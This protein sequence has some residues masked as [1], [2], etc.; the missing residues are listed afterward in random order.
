MIFLDLTKEYDALDRYRCLGILEGYG[1]GPGARRLLSNYWRRLTM[2]ARAGGYYGT[3]FGGERGVTQGD[4]P[5][6]TLFNVVVDAVVRHWLDGLRNDND[7]RKAEGGRDIS[8]RCSM[9]MMGWSE[10]G[11]PKGS[12]ALSAPWSPFS[13]G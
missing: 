11:T 10:R 3:A 5:S 6:P 7:E 13:T 1:V 8:R 4:P 9:Q 2:A 12:R